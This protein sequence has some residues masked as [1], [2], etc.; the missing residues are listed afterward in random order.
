MA[1]GEIKVDSITFTANGSDTTVSVSGLVQN[2]TFSGDITVTGTISGDIVQGGTLVSGATVSGTTANFV[3][4]SGTTVTGGNGNFTAVTTT[5]AN[6]TSGVFASGTAGAPSV[7]VGTTDNG[8]YSP[9]ADQVAISTNGTGRLFIDSS[10]NVGVGNANPS[11]RLFVQGP[12]N[13]TVVTL[14]GSSGDL[15]RNLT[16][17]NSNNDT[18]WLIQNNKSNGHRK[19]GTTTISR[20]T[21]Y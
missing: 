14:I 3:T 7:S 21:K 10:G 1:Y 16:I 19:D 17:S 15:T 20:Q 18:D 2:P 5:T 12:S 11:S 6:V 4:V 13:G 8:I 9:G